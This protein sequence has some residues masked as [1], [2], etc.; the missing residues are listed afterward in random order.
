MSS[1]TAASSD[2]SRPVNNYVHI[3]TVDL[4]RPNARLIPERQGYQVLTP[5]GK[6]ESSPFLV[7]TLHG[8]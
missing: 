1:W 8:P 2:C 4:Y 5:F 3:K 7:E 6:L